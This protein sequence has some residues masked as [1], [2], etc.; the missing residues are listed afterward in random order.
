[1]TDYGQELGF[2]LFLSPNVTD[3]EQTLELARLADVTG[4]D[5]VAVQ[6]HPYQARH[7]D[8]WTLLSVIAARTTAV[9]VALDVANLPLRQPVVLAKSVASLDL[10]S[11][12]R[13]ELGL[14]TGGFWDAIAAAGG[15]RRAPGEAVDALVE[16]IGIIRGVWGLE[17]RKS[18]TVEGKHYS[19]KGLHAG[20]APAHAVEIWLGAY[21][22]RMLRV[23]G[24]LAQG[25]LPSMGY[26]DPEALPGMNAVIDAAAEAAGRQPGAVRRMYNVFGRFG[27]GSGFLEGPPK[28]WAEQ[29]AELTLEA[30]MSTYI[31]GTGSIDDARRFAEEVAPAVRERVDAERART[32]A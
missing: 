4:L 24:R 13:V 14:G 16:A 31:L 23:T 15:P 26:A 25:W 21:R 5:L 2:G 3:L 11:G 29:L 22:P 12:G 20:P 8:A 27:G 9:R 30:G 7:V 6:D 17:G 18:V 32:P 1:M 19:V 10:L 28:A